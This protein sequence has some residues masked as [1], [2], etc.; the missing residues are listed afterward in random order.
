MHK[1]KGE[2]PDQLTGDHRHRE[3]RVHMHHVVV[4]PAELHH[5]W[6]QT[7]KRSTM[8]FYEDRVNYFAAAAAQGG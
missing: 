6:C 2:G 7:W 3:D 8:D 4:V 5:S 1:Q